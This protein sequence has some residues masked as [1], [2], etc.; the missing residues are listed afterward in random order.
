MYTRRTALTFARRFRSCPGPEIMKK[1]EYKTQIQHHFSICPYC[2]ME[3][4]DADPCFYSMAERLKRPPKG[5]SATLTAGDICAVKPE[6]GTWQDGF[7]YH[8]PVI[9][10]VDTMR[11][12]SQDILVAQTYDDLL[13]AGPGD[14]IVYD[15]QT[16]VGD[17]FIECWNMYILKKIHLGPPMANLDHEIVAA[18]KTLA[19][20]PE[21]AAQWV[22]LSVPLTENDPRI[23]F[24]DLEIEVGRVMSKQA[25]GIAL[26]LE[27]PDKALDAIPPE[28]LLTNLRRIHSGIRWR[29][30]PKTNSQVLAFA[31]FPEY[32]LPL[33]AE[34]D[35]EKT[36]P[37]M[38]CC[39]AGNGISQIFYLTARIH[40]VIEKKQQ[41]VYAG[42]IMIA[43]K[44]FKNS[45]M[46][47][48]L[49]EEN[50]PETEVLIAHKVSWDQKKGF[51]LA[52]FQDTS[53]LNHRLVLVVVDV[54]R[55][56]H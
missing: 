30:T 42:E 48:Y 16:G 17:L 12:L 38:C 55:K 21:N 39:L 18:V 54:I 23:Y 20:S 37:V 34:D 26:C 35:P 19:A 24:R 14:L 53:A 4:L 33:A 43:D 51:F 40:D 47:A 11:N 28:I 50:H 9:L 27:D 29:I 3:N 13:L 5:F 22:P 46:K 1:T 45:R 25:G 31:Q 10:V 44:V 56:N 6:Y 36:I 41:V 2:S 32:E 49:V 52:D 8:P 15:T 7:Y